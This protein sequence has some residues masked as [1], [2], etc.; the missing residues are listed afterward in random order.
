MWRSPT[1]GTARKA[2][3][4]SG[5]GDGEEGQPI[6]KGDQEGEGAGQAGNQPGG[7]IREVE[8]TLDELADMLGEALELPNIEPKGKNAIT[9]KKDKYTSIR[10]TG[11][12]SLRHFKSDL[13]SGPS[14]G[15][16]PRTNTTPKNPV[17]IPTNDDERFRSWKTVMEPEANA[18]IIYMMDVSGSMTDDQK[19][20]VRIESFWID[21]WLQET[22]RRRAKALHHP[23]RRR[24][25]S[26]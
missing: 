15:R 12:D 23:R 5:Q 26:R 9:T 1:S 2:R 4:A 24:P 17:I 14:A 20:I 21:T 22:I 10:Q 18:A 13:I 25:R 19:E 16:S 3:E 8:I 6:G 7:H 11:P